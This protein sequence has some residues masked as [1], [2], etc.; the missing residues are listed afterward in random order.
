MRVAKRFNISKRK[1]AK[2]YFK[3]R[4]KLNIV[5]SVL[6]IV[7]L[8][9]FLISGASLELK[10]IISSF[11]EKNWLV[12]TVYFSI[13]L[14]LFD[15]ITL[16]TNFH[17]N[18]LIEHKFKLSNQSISAWF[19]ENIKKIIVS[20]VMG[21]IFIHTIYYFLENYENLWWFYTSIV[22]IFF[23]VIFSHLAPILLIPI[24]YKLTPIENEALKS[25]LLSLCKSINAQVK[26][27]Y[28]INLSKDTKK[29]NAGLT[30]IGNTRC[31][32]LSDTLLEK[33]NLKEI[34]VIFSHELGHH[35]HRHIWKLIG[36]EIIFTFIGLYFIDISLNGFGT[37]LNITKISN[38]AN[39]PLLALS[40][41]IISF[42]F[43]PLKNAF[44]RALEREAD[45][46]ALDT[47]QNPSSF[48]SSMISLG[49]QNLSEIKPHPLIEAY[50]YSHPPL[51]KR[52]RM[53]YSYFK[54]IE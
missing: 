37:L 13:V 3:I 21:L 44:S 49:D 25:K 26:G 31:V 10:N 40:F 1:I 22:F 14:I 32:I 45:K 29:A 12:T 28:E 16:P 52:L 4:Y 39:L 51:I 20:F 7:I 17:V 15:L 24:F 50:F 43:I 23:G 30:G 53:G 48:I 18:F 8:A 42:F 19:L 6:H 9:T 2:E 5:Y 46:F 47:T 36:M 34:E 54:K 11:V 33:F 35:Y 38:I 41:S 27:V